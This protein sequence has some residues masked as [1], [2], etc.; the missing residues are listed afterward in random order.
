[1]ATSPPGNYGR[2]RREV[3]SGIDCGGGASGKT[4]EPEP[5]KLEVFC[6]AP[7]GGVYPWP[8]GREAVRLTIFQSARGSPMPLPA[9]AALSRTDGRLARVGE[10]AIILRQSAR[11]TRPLPQACGQF[12]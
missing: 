9:G 12:A 8:G 7:P 2:G 3:P 10:K 4:P 1:M 6:F 11:A 5:L